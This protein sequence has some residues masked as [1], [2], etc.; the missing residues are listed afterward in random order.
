MRD[1]VI[2]ALE[3]ADAMARLFTSEEVHLAQTFA[4]HA[5]L[6]LENARLYAELEARVRQI[7]A[8]QEQLLQAGKLAA[9]GQLVSGVAHEINNPLAVIVGSG[10]AP[11][12]PAHS[13]R[14]TCS[15]WTGSAPA[16]CRRRRSSASCRP[17]CSPRPR[18]VT[19][20]DLRD[21]IARILALREDALR[22]GG[23]ALVREMP[24]APSR[25]CAGTPPSSSRCS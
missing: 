16:A 25:S 18:E 4:D 7:E 20:V 2:G 6:S 15:A 14:T 3:V 24:P 23:I 21:V 8:S 9:V 5:A 12:P 13:I 17:S 10:P 11:G 1:T 19:L 22:V